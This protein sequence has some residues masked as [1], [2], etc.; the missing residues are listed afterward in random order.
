MGKSIFI[1]RGKVN[2]AKICASQYPNLLGLNCLDT[3]RD[4][5]KN[6]KA[7]FLLLMYIQEAIRRYCI[8]KLEDLAKPK[9]LGGWGIQNIDLFSKAL[10]AKTLWRFIQNPETLWG[11]VIL[12][13]YCSNNII[14]EWLRNL[15]KSYKNGSIG[16]KAM[17]LSY[18]L[19]GQ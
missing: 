3:K 15:D 12:N 5:N 13:K 4:P 1:K 17:V 11:R 19:I 2:L 8:G 9:K 7:M 10:A 16:W 6:K 14:T 18:P